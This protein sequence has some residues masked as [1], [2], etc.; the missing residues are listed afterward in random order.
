MY[1]FAVITKGGIDTM[2]GKLRL[3]LAQGLMPQRYFDIS[4]SGLTTI[5]EQ[6]NGRIDRI[7]NPTA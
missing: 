5:V 4:T 2:D 1:Q 7:S 6:G 3:R